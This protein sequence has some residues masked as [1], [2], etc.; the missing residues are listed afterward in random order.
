MSISGTNNNRTPLAQGPHEN[1][2]PVGSRDGKE[3]LQVRG[4]GLGLRNPKGSEV[5]PEPR[6]RKLLDMSVAPTSAK[7]YVSANQQDKEN[8][9]LSVSGRAMSLE[10]KGGIA[11]KPEH[12]ADAE[13]AQTAELLAQSSGVGVGSEE[14]Q[15]E[16]SLSFESWNNAI[17]DAAPYVDDVVD[18]LFGESY[19]SSGVSDATKKI[20]ALLSDPETNLARFEKKLLDTWQATASPV[21]LEVLKNKLKSKLIFAWQ[22]MG[23]GDLYKLQMVMES[24]CLQPG[25][26]HHQ[27]KELKAFIQHEDQVIQAYRDGF[28]Y[29]GENAVDPLHPAGDVHR[30]RKKVVA[31]E[32]TYRG[33]EHG[34]VR[35]ESNIPDIS[36]SNLDD[37]SLVQVE[38]DLVIKN[39]GGKVLKDSV[40]FSDGTY[41]FHG[42]SVEMEQRDKKISAQLEKATPEADSEFGTRIRAYINHHTA[43]G[44]DLKD[45]AITG[46]ANVCLFDDDPVSG[47]RTLKPGVQEILDEHHLALVVPSG[48]VTWGR[49]ISDQLHKNAKSS[50]LSG[51]RDTMLLMVPVTSDN[52]QTLRALGADPAL[53]QDTFFP[54]KTLEGLSVNAVKP[55]MPESIIHRLSAD[56]HQFSLAFNDRVMTD[57]AILVGPNHIVGNTADCKGIGTEGKSLTFD[58]AK[59]VWGERRPPEEQYEEMAQ[60]TAQVLSDVFNGIMDKKKGS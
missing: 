3:V 43:H 42:A 17:R 13:I 27:S 32:S 55:E 25:G 18:Y 2:E 40:A 31:V 26:G 16:L 37:S 34:T 29:D 60:S 49:P 14:R 8:Q 24:L 9:N 23:Q 51:Y 48:K 21:H 12:C 10:K 36:L 56:R 47:L 50:E 53:K 1:Q 45:L 39:A 30:S 46:D 54:L 19:P 5:M 59:E 41:S 57:H 4:R 33:S 28:I 6:K 52:L 44:R 58:K 22:R 20:E 7:R 35:N 15:E 11:T 38:D